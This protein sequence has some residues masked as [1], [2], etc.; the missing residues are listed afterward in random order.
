MMNANIGTLDRALRL[1]ASLLLAGT[2]AALASSGWAIAALAIGAVM[3]LTAVVGV[4]PAYT[5]LGI[6]TRGRRVRA[7]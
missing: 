1:V 6:D 5:L 4:C 3:G 7:S 2:G